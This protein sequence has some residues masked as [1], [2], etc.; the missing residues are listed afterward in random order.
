M[1]PLR[2]FDEGR[3]RKGIA[4]K[5]KGPRYKLRPEFRGIHGGGERDVSYN[6]N[7]NASADSRLRVLFNRPIHHRI[8]RS[9]RRDP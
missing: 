4:A 3:C 8:A 9:R 5:R 1:V 6:K 7:E 2:E